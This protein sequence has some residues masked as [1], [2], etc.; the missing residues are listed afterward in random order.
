MIRCY[1]EP[2]LWQKKE[3]WISGQ[4]AHHLGC[5]LRV[6]PGESVV[7]LDGLGRWAHAEVRSVGKKA[8]LLTLG[9]PHRFPPP[10]VEITLG[11]GIPGQGKL[12][13][14]VSVATQLGAAQ[15]VALLTAR[16]IVRFSSDRFE[17]KKAHLHRVAIEA[18]KQSGSGWLPIITPPCPWKAFLD[19]FPQFDRILMALPHGPHDR[20]SVALSGSLRKILILIGPEGD[21]TEEEVREA[22]SRGAFQV[23]L[24]P[25][26]LRTETACTAALAVA[27]YL[28]R[29]GA[30]GE[31]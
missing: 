21:W 7:C 16:S 20:W 15:V 17:R 19:Q 24:G 27:Q 29:E 6:R 23:G 30:L 12:E 4:E 25:S 10:A 13:E 22:K 18:L 5:V 14:V 9:K 1:L 3:V 26:I 8:L 28:M 2:S 11:V 31:R